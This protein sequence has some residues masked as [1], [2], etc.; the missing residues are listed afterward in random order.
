MTHLTIA[1]PQT[2][3]PFDGIKRTDERGDFWSARELQPHLGYDQ[4]RRFE[5]SIERA[6]AAIQN[7]GLSADDHVADAGNMITVGKGA[8]RLVSD[9]RLTRYGAY[10]VAMNGDPRKPEVAAAQ[11]YFAVRTHEAELTGAHTLPGDLPSA[12]RAYADEVEARAALEAKVATDAPKVGYVDQYVADDD[13]LRFRTVAARL[14]IQETAL[15]NLLIARRWIYVEASTRWSNSQGTKV[16]VSRYS[17]YADFKQYFQPIPRHEAPRF[18]GE[19]MHTLKITPT[20]AEAIAR[21]VQRNT[22][23]SA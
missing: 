18:K 9:Y 4:W 6:R 20:G 19:V 3:T 22:A 15:R 14:G 11:T 17:A 5:D 21:L 16:P 7:S 10:I 8:T 12:L 1:Q 23:V 2:A 13:L